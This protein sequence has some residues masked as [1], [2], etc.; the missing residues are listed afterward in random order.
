MCQQM[1]HCAYFLF[2]L[3]FEKSRFPDLSRSLE[4]G[5]IWHPLPPERLHTLMEEMLS[6]VARFFRDPQLCR[7]F[8]LDKNLLKNKLVKNPLLQ[9]R[10]DEYIPFE[11]SE[12]CL[13]LFFSGH[14]FL[15]LKAS[16]RQPV[17]DIREAVLKLNGAL[18]IIN[19]RLEDKEKFFLKMPR[20]I[21]SQRS[22]D[23]GPAEC[24]NARIRAKDIDQFF[25]Q[26]Q[27]GRYC[28]LRDLLVL[29]LKDKGID[30]SRLSEF[31]SEHIELPKFCV[32]LDPE[33]DAG[34][35]DKLATFRTVFDGHDTLL[36][37]EDFF[38]PF[39]DIRLYFSLEGGVLYINNQTDSK[40]ARSLFENNQSFVIILI[41]A[42]LQKEIFARL[43][44][45]IRALSVKIETGRPWLNSIIS[46]LNAINLYFI[47]SFSLIWFNAISANNLLNRCYQSW[48][49]VLNCHTDYQEVKNK[50]ELFNEY[51]ERRNHRRFNRFSNAI[52]F[53]FF[54]LTI[55]AGML[56]M[57]IK[58]LGESYRLSFFND[59]VFYLIG[60]CFVGVVGS[61]AWIHYKDD[62]KD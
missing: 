18:D 29:L 50:L 17:P 62:G 4:T 9:Y 16:V 38:S 11:I 37:S 28:Y 25:R 61:W 53:L 24:A 43:F 13:F 3:N 32:C 48:Q 7:I 21:C 36:N 14:G 12:I 35:S 23:N 1:K 39:K 41:V 2:P 56:G 57:N 20:R 44:V 34:F 31:G 26:Y 22:L 10:P 58:E 6:D 47:N 54:P 60:I 45:D 19:P 55:A 15:L 33:P 59:M 42:W 51:L 40:L 52:T 30:L 8:E 46:R 5:D 49:K 27:Q